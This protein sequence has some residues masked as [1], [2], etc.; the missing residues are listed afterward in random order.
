MTAAADKPPDA[1]TGQ[2][3]LKAFTLNGSVL[4][5]TLA[6]APG[7]EPGALGL[8]LELEVPAPGGWKTIRLH[9]ADA[10][11][12]AAKREACR[13][14]WPWAVERHGLVRWKGLQVANPGMAVVV[15]GEVQKRLDNLLP[16][17]ADEFFSGLAMR[18]RRPLDA[19]T[20]VCIAGKLFADNRLGPAARTRLAMILV[21]KAIE[22]LPADRNVFVPD[23]ALEEAFTLLQQ[24]V[25]SGDGGRI[26][27]LELQRL[28]LHG[29]LALR[30]GR[31]EEAR[32]YLE[33]GLIE[34]DQSEDPMLAA[35]YLM[36]T[37][38]LLA[39][40][41]IHE[42]RRSLAEEWLSPVH[43]LFVQAAALADP[44]RLIPYVR[45]RKCFQLAS[46][47]RRTLR[48]LADKVPVP[49]LLHPPLLLAVNLGEPAR[50]TALAHF[51]AIAD[52]KPG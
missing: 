33:A 22:R 12:A 35:E 29:T 26:A 51:G 8:S 39:C 49:V 34:L 41:A 27:T 44:H 42:G 25:V 52:G 10:R 15:P 38:L 2:P 30:L 23:P 19:E 47:A 17:T 36:R 5:V 37:R 11:V 21:Y 43:P 20:Q 3:V 45:M 9:Q 28:T 6:L 13:L 16:T 46:V 4:G 50:S 40:L 31:F 7:Q 1:G 18:D 24:P 14:H 32:P 48:A